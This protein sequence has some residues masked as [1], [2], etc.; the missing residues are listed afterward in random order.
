MFWNKT[1]KLPVTA[2]DKEWVEEAI[3]HLKKIFS[4]DYFLQIDTILPTKKHYDYDFKGTEEDA[5]FVLEQTKIYMDVDYENIKL[6]FFSHS[7]VE[8][9]D[10]TILTTPSDNINGSWKSAAGTYEYDGN[11]VIISIEKSQ[12]KD[13]QALIAT[14]AHEL[15]HEILLGEGHLEENDEYLT[16]LL[17]VI[18]GFGI[19]LGNTKFTF[20]TFRT[21]HGS[22]WQSSG[23]GYL[24]EQV[25]AYA[26]AWLC[27]YRKE[28]P[29]WKDMLN[30][31]MLKYFNQS[32]EYIQ[33]H[34]DKIR[35]E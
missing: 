3:L 17:A 18:Y 14:I 25:I 29:V 31:S 1:N 9:A 12:L 33:K 5:K 4:P 20:N 23:T 8:M 32:F 2:E 16:D 11:N 15:C 26:M 35:F 28:E 19:F 22:G 30:A 34:P 13:P 21:A 10:G 24:P 6:D 7:P 27:A